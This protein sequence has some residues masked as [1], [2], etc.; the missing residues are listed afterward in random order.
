[1]LRLHKSVTYVPDFV[2]PSVGRSEGPI[3]QR[4]PKDRTLK[5]TVRHTQRNR[6]YLG[7]ALLFTIGLGLASRK[8][9]ALFPAALEKYP[10]DALWAQMVYW[11]V[12]ICTPTASVI[13][14]VLSSLAISYVDEISQLYQAPWINSIRAT[15]PGHLVL[16]SHF[17]W[18]DMASY[19][20]GIAIVA[21]IDGWFL[22]KRY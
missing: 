6:I 14:V 5:K 4:F 2:G 16:G 8:F 10:G 7:A 17:S 20:I 9:P 1:L 15:T 13:K 22:R 21:L 18:I 12:C 11:L 19:T 3:N